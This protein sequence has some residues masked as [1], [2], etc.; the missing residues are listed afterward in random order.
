[1]LTACAG[2]L[3]I[4]PY[5]AS[6]GLGAYDSHKRQEVA[7]R[8]RYIEE[9]LPIERPKNALLL[10][11]NAEREAT[12]IITA[13]L[14]DKKEKSQVKLREA[15]VYYKIAETLADERADAWLVNIKRFMSVSLKAQA[16]NEFKRY[17]LANILS[18][19]TA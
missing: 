14:P 13:K 19:Y 17:T 18:C 6:A 4:L 11:V 1:M 10:G 2:P 12:R 7:E 8:K 16:E 15:Y 3:S 5:M 9:C